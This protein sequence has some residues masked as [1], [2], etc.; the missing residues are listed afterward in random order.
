MD[1]FRV[2]MVDVNTQEPTQAVYV[3]AGCEE[4]AV[5]I[6]EKDHPGEMAVTATW[7]GASMRY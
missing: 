5:A 4:G 7:T 6:A 1:E 3:W 2:E